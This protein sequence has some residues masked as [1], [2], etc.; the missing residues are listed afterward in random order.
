MQIDARGGSPAEHRFSAA[1]VPGVHGRLSFARWATGLLG[2]TR[3]RISCRSSTCLP[4][5][6][7]DA[8]VPPK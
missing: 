2:Q 7:P 1:M 6:D 5:S 3:G 8:F 4:A